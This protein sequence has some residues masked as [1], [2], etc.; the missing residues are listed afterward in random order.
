MKRFARLAT[1]CL[2]GTLYVSNA[3]QAQT[4]QT[5]TASGGSASADSRFYVELN[6]GPT[7][8]HKSDSFIG[9][10]VGVRLI[11]D[12][13]GFMEV[14]HM[15]NVGTSKLDADAATIASFIGGTVN[16]TGIASTYV[17]FGA[18]Y[19]LTMVPVV[20][21]YV[22]LGIGV[23]KTTR[24]VV[25]SVNGTEIDPA[26][27]GVQLGGDLTGTTTKAFIVAGGGIN[28]PFLDRYFADLGYRYGHI[29]AKTGEVETDRS[30]KT[31]RIVLGV[32]VRF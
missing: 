6:A 10:E 8:G 16:S 4:T 11:P 19:H 7:L 29:G 2:V 32:G 1:L 26:T 28:V 18:R 24:E 17:D 22:L 25:F 14:G 3:A 15:G 13:D 9:G 31:Q 27:R 21:P 20:H 5:T 12:L 30:I 23:A